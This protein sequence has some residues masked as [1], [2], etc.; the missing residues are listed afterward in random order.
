MLIKKIISLKSLDA[1][2]LVLLTDNVKRAIQSLNRKG[3]ELEENDLNS[4]ALGL[5]GY[6]YIN[7]NRKFYCI[8]KIEPSIV[9]TLKIV[10]HELFHANQDIL[11][12]KDIKYKKGDAN[13]AYAYT[14]DYLFGEV[15]KEVL[16][17]HNKK[18]NNE[19]SK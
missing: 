18:Y 7:D 14:L 16:K 15:Y 19:S 11:E 2:L 4:K 17:A 1:N 9:E 5:T 13:E 8:V 3:F 6:S 12:F 10:V